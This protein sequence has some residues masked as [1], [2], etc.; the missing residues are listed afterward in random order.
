MKMKKLFGV[1]SIVM[2]L[3]AVISLIGGYE[4]AGGTYITLFILTGLLF[5]FVSDKAKW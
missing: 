1:L 4:S 3:F 2:L 5:M